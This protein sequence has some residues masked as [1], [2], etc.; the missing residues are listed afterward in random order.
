MDSTG[1]GTGGMDTSTHQTTASTQITQ[2]AIEP[3]PSQSVPSPPPAEPVH[4]SPNPPAKPSDKQQVTVTAEQPEL[5][6]GILTRHH[7]VAGHRSIIEIRLENSGS[8]AVEE[9]DF[10]IDSKGIA[11]PLGWRPRRI[12][13]GLSKTRILEIDPL[14]AGH[15]VLR[16][17][18]AFFRSGQRLSLT[19]Q[20]HLQILESPNNPDLHI[21]IQDIQCNRGSAANQGLGA[22]FGNV[23]IRD[24]V[25]KEIYQNLN[26]LLTAERSTEFEPVE[27]ELDYEISAVSMTTQR[28]SHSRERMIARPF[29]GSASTARTLHLVP[30]DSSL[31]TVRLTARPGYC[32]GRSRSECDLVTWFLPRS[33]TNDNRTRRL[34]K[35]HAVCELR[36]NRLWF[37]DNGSAN[38]SRWDGIEADAET[39]L[40]MDERGEILLGR[41]FPVSVRCFPAG[42]EA[43]I[44]IRNLRSWNGSTGNT[45]ET[46]LPHF[47]AARFTPTGDPAG[48]QTCWVLSM[49]TF[50]TSRSNPLILTGPGIEEIHGIFR[51][52]HGQFWVE[53]AAQARVEVDGTPLRSSEMAPLCRGQRIQLGE[54]TLR[55][56][57]P[58]A[59]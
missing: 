56:E 57:T 44:R 53:P 54:T 46:S 42:K 51:F 17:Q 12:D 45:S 1:P 40:E 19:G 15:Y 39:G 20:T 8:S 14:E 5:G 31:P 22:E 33:E 58:T 9:V 59:P 2:P 26:D 3:T 37:R 24:L 29:I 52:L 50:G 36:E 43:S 7:L 55:I 6:L 30:V 28:G 18:V 10:S 32:L 34:S 16:I 27:L 13:A 41:D 48:P 23:E 49:A 38:G 4:P 35:I 21:N 47:A 25:G 11:Q